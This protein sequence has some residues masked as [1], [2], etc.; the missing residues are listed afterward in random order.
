M[1]YGI[2]G[3]VAVVT[4]AASGIGLATARMLA[5]EGARVV[6]SDQ[7]PSSLQTAADRLR[8]AAG[9]SGGEVVPV[10]AD[11][12]STEQAQFMRRAVLD[13]VGP[14]SIL[15]NAAGIAG[16]VGPFHEVDEA[17]WI[18]T[19]DTDLMGA[20]RLLQAFVPDM[21]GQGWGRI[22]LIA[23]EN[24]RQ[25][26]PDE[27]AFCAAKA[28]I[29]NL[30]KGL[31]KAYAPEGILVNTV[32]PAFI[33]TPMTDAM[34]DRRAKKNASSREQAIVSFLNEQRPTLAL[35][36]RGEPEEVAAAI[37]FLCSAQASF[38]TGSDLRVD[39]GS[40]AAI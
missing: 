31:S 9:E 33:A 5:A 27:L 36:R 26:Y 35:K 32:S 34:M 30:A 40:V 20:V 3:R 1:D 25:P 15:V 24:A 13:R 6:M 28:A 4:G 17:G 12:T 7:Y 22:V 38:I 37:V 14:P 11:L 39:G 8:D 19:L 16:A 10:A 21:R 23:G 18:S 2:R 29:L